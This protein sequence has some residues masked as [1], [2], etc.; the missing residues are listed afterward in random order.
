MEGHETII[1]GMV[2]LDLATRRETGRMRLLV[3]PDKKKVTL[4]CF[5]DEHV[6]PGS[7]ISTDGFNS[8]SFLSRRGSN[9][10]HR[11][12]N[13][14]AREFSR[15]EAIFGVN[16]V[17]TTNA[18]EGLFG[19]VKTFCRQRQFRRVSCKA[20]GLLMAEF[21]WRRQTL[22]Q[23]SEWKDAGLW[24]LLELVAAWQE[25]VRPEHVLK[26]AD[27][28]DKELVDYREST[29]VIPPAA[30]E[31]VAAPAGP[32]PVLPA[33]PGAFARTSAAV[34]RRLQNPPRLL[35]R[36]RYDFGDGSAPN[37]LSFPHSQGSPVRPAEYSP[38]P[39]RNQSMVCALEASSPAALTPCTASLQTAAAVTPTGPPS[40]PRY[41]NFAEEVRAL[42]AE[43]KEGSC[44]C[45]GSNGCSCDS[46]ASSTNRRR[47][48]ACRTCGHCC[49]E[50]ERRT[51]Q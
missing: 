30:P 6:H 35:A 29:K 44:F 33:Q 20:Y 12:I 5:I 49:Q 19:R 14:K 3:I 42:L 24:K 18:A 45:G 34:R 23:N 32:V 16:V 28:L 11:A 38:S 22:G 46:P 7:L 21:I 48:H 36:A 40:P 2:E 4:K 9:F 10:V 17:V 26:V 25:V 51:E 31:P 1:L 43:K 41:P 13:H 39:G 50:R 37:A 15:T 27:W 47:P 8:Y